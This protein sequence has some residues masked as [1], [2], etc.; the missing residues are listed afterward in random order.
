MRK[1]LSTSS[2]RPLFLLFFFLI[3]LITLSLF[4]YGCADNPCAQE[5]YIKCTCCAT[6]AQKES[7]KKKM[8]IYVND[9]REYI[10]EEKLNAC[11]KKV[12]TFKCENELAVNIQ[13]YCKE[14]K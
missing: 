3:S 7:C 2:F 8:D 6:D 14:S 13:D 12:D 11:R 10:P 4:S 9:Q 1:N 5:W